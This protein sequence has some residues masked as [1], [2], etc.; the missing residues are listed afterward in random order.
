V[1]AIA[2]S[3]DGRFVATGDRRRES[4]DTVIASGQWPQWDVAQSVRLWDTASG[5]ELACFDGFKADV[6]ALTFSPDGMELAAGLG[7]STILIWDVAKAK[8][9]CPHHQNLPAMN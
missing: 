7:D 5:K 9:A 6:T 8:R 3:P 4:Y 2:W 1:S